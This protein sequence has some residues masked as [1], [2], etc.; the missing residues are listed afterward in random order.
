[1]VCREKLY[2]RIW[3][4]FIICSALIFTP[5]LS[6]AGT[7]TLSLEDGAGIR[8]TDWGNPY[9]PESNTVELLLNNPDDEVKVLQVDICSS[10][11]GGDLIFN[12]GEATSRS[13]HLSHSFTYNSG[14]VE[15]RFGLTSATIAQG[16]GSVARLY[17]DVS[18]FVVDGDC[19]PLTIDVIQVADENLDPVTVDPDPPDSGEFCYYKCG[20]NQHCDDGLFCNGEE[21]CLSGFCNESFFPDPCEPLLCNEGTDQCYCD[22][23]GQC[24]DGDWCNGEETCSG[25]ECD[26]G[27]PP[28]SDDFDSCTD[29]CDG[30]LETCPYTCNAAGPWDACCQSSAACSTADVCNEEITLTLGN[31]SGAPGSLNNEVV[32]G[33][34]NSNNKVKAVQIEI[35]DGDDYLDVQ[36]LCEKEPSPRVP[37]G[38]S[39]QCTEQPSGCAR[40]V[41]AQE[42]GSDFIDEGSGPLFTVKYD[43]LPY[44]PTPYGQCRDL[45]VDGEELN[46]FTKECNEDSSNPGTSCVS[47]VD[48]PGG[49]CELRSLV[50]MPQ[51]GEFCFP[52]TLSSACWD[53]N[54]CTSESC[55]GGMCVYSNLTSTC[56]DGDPCTEGDRCRKSDLGGPNVCLGSDPCEELD[57]CDGVRYCSGGSCFAVGDPCGLLTCDDGEALCVG[58]DV[59]LTV[60]NAYGREGVITV[61]LTNDNDQVDEVHLNLCDKDLRDWLHISTEGCDNADR[62]SGFN[63]IISD[64]GGGCVGVDI[65][66]TFPLDF[67]ETGTGPIAQISYTVDPIDIR[68]EVPDDTNYAD[69]NPESIVVEDEDDQELSVTPKPGKLYA[70]EYC[71]GDFDG[72]GSVEAPDATVFLS[73]LYKRLA[74]SNPCTNEDPCQ[75]DFNCDTSVDGLEIGPFLEDWNKRLTL[76]GGN[77]CPPQSEQFDCVY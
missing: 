14:C 44:P 49:A 21:Q 51:D 69:I 52:C 18:Q 66:S 64:L 67:I 25:G 65:E 76:P 34:D 3:V 7:V 27:S 28:C 75:A 15:V 61:A 17:F 59:T 54:P 31:G 74:I 46:V 30:S 47:D 72:N 63:C 33:L 13:D 73:E 8:N 39:C 43:V 77:P 53:G 23:D 55:D 50:A 12:S 6:G 42:F 29:D 32:V 1:M 45:T 56:D 4:M 60:E 36:S 20:V 2:V 24:D 41:L 40:C 5:S 9:Y 71:Q 38:F 35:C 19:T 57:Y 48:C 68:L 16:S 22:A 70:A 58:S 10:D 62:T 37:N 26:T 11:I